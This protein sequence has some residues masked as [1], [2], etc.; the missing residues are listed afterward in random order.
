MKYRSLLLCLMVSFTFLIAYLGIGC[1]RKK[2]KTVEQKK[3]ARS[4]AK[5]I[6]QPETD[7]KTETKIDIPDVSDGLE[8]VFKSGDAVTDFKLRTTEGVETSL[9][10]HL[11][12]KPVLLEFGAYT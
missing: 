1:S 11:E 8:L 12:S 5:E 6:S 3:P 4:T 10:Q 7:K 9:F 2:E